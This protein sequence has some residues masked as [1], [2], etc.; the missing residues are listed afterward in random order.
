VLAGDLAAVFELPL[1]AALQCHG[2]QGDY[3]HSANHDQNDCDCAHHS[4]SFQLTV[5]EYRSTSIAVV[6]LAVT[7]SPQW[8]A[9]GFKGK[10][11]GR[12]LHRKEAETCCG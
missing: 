5:I 8:Q 9:G 11:A 12:W 6:A 4:A 2:K 1:A 3:D 7:P 10:L